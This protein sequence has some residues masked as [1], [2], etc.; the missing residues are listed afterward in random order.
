[1]QNPP[2]Q[3]IH[4]SYIHERIKWDTHT[5]QLFIWPVMKVIFW[6]DHRLWCV[7]I[8]RG[9]KENLVASVCF[10]QCGHIKVTSFDHHHG[11]PQT[12]TTKV[13]YPAEIASKH[14]ITASWVK[15]FIISFKKIWT[16]CWKL[17]RQDIGY[18]KYW[19]NFWTVDRFFAYINKNGSSAPPKYTP[20]YLCNR[21]L[22]Y[23]LISTN[24]D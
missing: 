21:V 8:P 1:M 12:S 20:S 2:F 16:D 19:R 14:N 13:F 17:P 15:S 5:V 18:F 23:K 11:L 6:R 4:V 22:V 7:T 3:E 24:E 10:L 9:W